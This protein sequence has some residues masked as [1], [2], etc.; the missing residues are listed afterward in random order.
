MTMGVYVIQVDCGKWWKSYVGI[1]NNA[2]HR[3]TTHKSKLRNGTHFNHYLQRA[4][5]KY[6]KEN[7]EF[8]L[9]EEQKEEEERYNLEKEYAYEFGYPDKDLCFNIGSP[10][11]KTPNLGRHLSKETKQKIS[12]FQKGRRKKTAQ[13]EKNHKAILTNLQARFILTVAAKDNYKGGGGCRRDFTQQDLANMFKVGKGC[14]RKIHNKE[15]WKHI[16][17]LSDEE[18]ESFKQ[19]LKI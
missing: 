15:S 9:L 8:I 3:W 11:E 2:K 17:P 14:I 16:E 19:S 12:N 7:F 4:W 10:G 1:S 13:G 5:D 6:G 18:Y